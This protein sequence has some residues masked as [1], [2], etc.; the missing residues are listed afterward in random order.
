MTGDYRGIRWAALFGM[1][2][3]SVGIGFMAYNAGLSHGLAQV[4]I[5]QG[6][7]APAPGPVPYPYPYAYGWHPFWGFGY[8]FHIF[9]FLM[10]L[11]FWIFI[12]RLFW[13]G[14]PWRRG[15]YGYG[16]Y[17]RRYGGPDA[18]D[19]WHQRAHERMKETPPA[20]D[21]GRGR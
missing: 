16:C 15:G 2:L 19:D 18:F 13:W 20:N 7:A 5:T 12:S 8:G 17:G 11:F 4:A 3:L 9:P 21:P 6:Q 10:F 14:G 1:L